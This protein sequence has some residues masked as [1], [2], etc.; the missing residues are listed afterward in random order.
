MSHRVHLGQESIGDVFLLRLRS[1]ALVT[2]HLANHE[3]HLLVPLP[4]LFLA[5]LVAVKGG[6]AGAA[7]EARRD[8]RGGELAVAAVAGPGH[9]SGF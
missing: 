9:N 7:S 4:V 1:G 5:R 8:P 3:A 2:T 6:V